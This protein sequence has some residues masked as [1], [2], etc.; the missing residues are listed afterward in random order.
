VLSA[1]PRFSNAASTRPTVASVCITKSAYALRPLLF[2]Q[3]SIT[4]SGVCGAVSGRYSRNG[5]GF[6]AEQNAA[7]L[8]DAH[9]ETE[10]P[11]ASKRELA[12]RIWDRVVELRESK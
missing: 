10:V 9:G 3:A 2:F 8:I 4:A 12:E 6:A 5:S 11:R 1:A 7:V